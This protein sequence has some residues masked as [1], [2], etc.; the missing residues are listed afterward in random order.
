MAEHLHSYL[1]NKVDSSKYF[2]NLIAL[3]IQARRAMTHPPC[4]D[5]DRPEIGE[6][7]NLL[8]FLAVPSLLS[9]CFLMVAHTFQ[10]MCMRLG[11]EMPLPSDPAPVLEAFQVSCRGRRRAR[12][13]PTQRAMGIAHLRLKREWLQAQPRLL[14][15][16][17]PRTRR[18]LLPNPAPSPTYALHEALQL[19]GFFAR[20]RHVPLP[21]LTA[22]SLPL[23]A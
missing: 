5:E 13:H 9:V 15:A 7:V 1:Q 12:I 14:R 16:P 11:E 23:L 20:M 21:A 3:Q 17:E 19:N 4:P 2:P 18:R 6:P 10:T 8:A 22:G